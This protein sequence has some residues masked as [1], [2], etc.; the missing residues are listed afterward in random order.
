[1]AKGQSA[2][3]AERGTAGKS[4]DRYNKIEMLQVGDAAPRKRIE[5]RKC[6]GDE[7]AIQKA[8]AP[9]YG[10]EHDIRAQIDRAPAR[11]SSCAIVGRRPSETRLRQITLA[12]GNRRI[13]DAQARDSSS[14]RCRPIDFRAHRRADRLAGDVQ[15]VR[16]AEAQAPVRGVQR[17][18]RR[19]RQRA[20]SSASEFGQ[21][22]PSSSGRAEA[23][24][25]RDE[26]ISAAEVFKQRRA[27]A[28]VHYRDVALK[29][30]AGR[31]SFLSRTIRS[32]WPSSLPRGA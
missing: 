23:I 18:R 29:R 19:D 15:R 31:R 4:G 8:A 30:R 21:R 24:L 9:K 14:T 6:R 25:R 11:S 12:M 5:A 26:C 28:R 20:W 7:H 1:M 22:S 3:K 10:H 16:E 17:S 27:C 32:S 13:P 2:K